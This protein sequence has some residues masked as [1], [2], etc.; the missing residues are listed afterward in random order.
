MYVTD[1]IEF[2]AKTMPNRP[3][4]M[5]PNMI[6]SYRALAESVDSVATRFARSKLDPAIPVGVAI[7]DPSKLLVACFALLRAGFTVAPVQPSHLPHLRASDIHQLVHM[8]ESHVL[9]GGMN[10]RFENSWLLNNRSS[11]SS[12]SGATGALRGSFGDVIFFTSGTT[13]I[14][15]KVVQRS[16]ATLERS[17]LST[18][19]GTREF[20][21]VL[22]APSATSSFG[23]NHACD[24]L[25]LG[26]TAC[27]CLF[28]EGM[29]A[30]I[31]SFR[32]DLVI[33]SSH[34]AIALAELKELHPGYPVD[35]L[36][37]IRIGGSFSSQEVIRRIQSSLC[38][39]IIVDYAGTEAWL[40]ATSPYEMIAHVPF[41]VGFVAPW[42]ELQIVDDEGSVLP[43][44]ADGQIRYR[45][46]FFLKNFPPE[47]A[48]EKTELGDQWFYPGDIGSLTKEGILCV[49]GRIDDLINRGGVK[50]SAATIE[51]ALRS[52]P[53]VLDAGVCGVWGDS[54]LQ[55]IWIAIV[56][57]SA[58]EVETLQ[59]FIQTDEAFR[60]TVKT[61][62][63]ELFL[64]ER[65]PRGDL[66]KIQRHILKD[67]LL[68]AKKRGSSH[69]E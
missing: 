40:A 59:R 26:K 15:K 38:Q 37:A 33:A 43:P 13:G 22:I 47:Q 35:S 12:Q 14:P 64:V 25:R 61:D 54:G 10:V 3:A 36:R 28:G 46:S 50:I 1:M 16:A 48:S 23:F 42:T 39:Q 65:I 8:E 5:L 27:F 67:A 29:L 53:G 17:N 9:F 19:T 69:G 55:E 6:I 62:V 57:D 51:E 7:E 31:G 4:I 45:N 63:D 66:G 20:S 60:N 41:A 11:I 32:I 49:K 2:W 56:G 34:Q 30:M 44:E 68:E 18:L 21:R 24:V 58:F 52:C